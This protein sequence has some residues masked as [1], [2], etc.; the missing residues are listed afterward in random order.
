MPFAKKWRLFLKKSSVRFFQKQPVFFS[1]HVRRPKMHKYTVRR[2]INIQLALN[3]FILTRQGEMPGEMCRK[4]QDLI[5]F[6]NI[7]LWLDGILP[8]FV[9]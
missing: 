3:G 1:K 2:C 6:K 5:F 7:Y 8:N 4:K 9:A